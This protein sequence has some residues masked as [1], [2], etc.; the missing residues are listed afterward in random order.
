LPQVK[1][2][3]LLQRLEKGAGELSLIFSFLLLYA[4]ERNSG[5]DLSASRGMVS[6]MLY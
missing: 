3:W 5:N 2:G 1:N 4:G 6:K